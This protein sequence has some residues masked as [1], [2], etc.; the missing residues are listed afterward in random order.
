[1]RLY[2]LPEAHILGLTG[3]PSLA[4]GLYCMFDSSSKTANKSALGTVFSMVLWGFDQGPE[5]TS[6]SLI[7]VREHQLSLPGDCRRVIELQNK[8]SSWSR[9]G[10]RREI[11][12]CKEA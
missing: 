1:M 6:Q 4:G 11:L 10:A 5:E 9:P 7:A 3:I 12:G 2:I 8:Q